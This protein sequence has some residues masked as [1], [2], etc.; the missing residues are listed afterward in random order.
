MRK[1]AGLTIE[2]RIALFVSGEEE[3]MKAVAEHEGVLHKGTLAA[4]TKHEIPVNQQ[5]FRI[6]ELDITVGFDKM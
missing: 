4:K 6:N 5:T 3:V 2:D 1:E